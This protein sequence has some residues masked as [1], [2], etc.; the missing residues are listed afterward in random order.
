MLNKSCE[1][2]EGVPGGGSCKHKSPERG[3]SF[4][5]LNEWKKQ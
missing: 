4:G 1:L 3:M 5:M 2:L